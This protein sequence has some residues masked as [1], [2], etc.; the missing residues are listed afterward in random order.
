MP[1]TAQ[2]TLSTVPKLI[3]VGTGTG[4]AVHNTDN[5][6]AIFVGDETVTSSTGFRVDASS[7]SASELVNL[8]LGPNERLYAVAASG[9]PVVHVY[10]AS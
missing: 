8:V 4:V 6:I 7:S 10:Q 9:A 2:V 3:A 1:K 5:T